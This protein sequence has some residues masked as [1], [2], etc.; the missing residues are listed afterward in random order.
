MGILDVNDVVSSKMPLAAL[1][2]AHTTN[3]AST[4]NHASRTHVPLDEVGDLVVLKIELDGV[5][6][7]NARIGVANGSAVVC[8]DM[9]N[10][11]ETQ[12]DTLHLEKLVIGFLGGDTVDGE[13]TLDVVDD[14]EVLV[15]L[16]DAHDVYINSTAQPHG[17]SKSRH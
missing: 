2:G 11:T 1:D 5:V 13:A 15:G 9:G 3:V 7:A 14:A 16:L 8:N 10:T 6:G 12:S 17:S 4:S